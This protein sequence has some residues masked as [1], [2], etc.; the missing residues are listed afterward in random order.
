LPMLMLLAVPDRA[1]DALERINA[2]FARH[3]RQF[4]V[5]ASAAAGT[6]LAVKGLVDLVN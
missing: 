4:A 2:W 1:S 5:V 6:Y 3:G